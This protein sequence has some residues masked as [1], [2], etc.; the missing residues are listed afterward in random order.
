[1]S[2]TPPAGLGSLV[3]AR[4]NSTSGFEVA[5][6]IANTYWLQRLRT[7]LS[8][9]RND[10]QNLR[11]L[12]NRD[13]GA[14][15]FNVTKHARHVDEINKIVF[16][17]VKRPDG[18]INYDTPDPTSNKYLNRLYRDKII[19]LDDVES[20]VRD[21]FR[22]ENPGLT[23]EQLAEREP[24][25]RERIAR[26]QEPTH[27]AY[28][29][30]ETAA[31]KY[32]ETLYLG[33]DHLDAM[34]A[35]NPGHFDH[36][37]QLFITGADPN[38]EGDRAAV[39]AYLQRPEMQALF[40]YDN[41]A[42][43]PY[44]QEIEA[45]LNDPIHSNKS[46]AQ[47]SNEL[48]DH[49]ARKYP[50]QSLIRYPLD[51]NGNPQILWGKEQRAYVLARDAAYKRY[52]EH[53][54]N[55]SGDLTP[56]GRRLFME[57][58]TSVDFKRTQA[59]ALAALGDLPDDF[60]PM[61]L[62]ELQQ[63]HLI[64]AV[65][66][67]DFAKLGHADELLHSRIDYERS[68][69]NDYPDS[70]KGEAKRLLALIE[71]GA[72]SPF[73]AKIALTA[74]AGLVALADMW[75]EAD[76]RGGFTSPEFFDY[77]KESADDM[78]KALPLLIA[79]E[80]AA[81][82]ASH[83]RFGRATLWTLGALGTAISLR[84]VLDYVTS[85]Y[86]V[87]PGQEGT[88]AAQLFYGLQSLDSFIDDFEK[89]IGGYIEKGLDVLGDVVS[90]AVNSAA[91]R[92]TDKI[93]ERLEKLDQEG[94]LQQV[95]GETATIVSDANEWIIGS[96]AA[97]VVGDKENNVLIHTGAGLVVGDEGDDSVIAFQAGP[98][99][100]GESLDGGIR[101][102]ERPGGPW[103][104]DKARAVEIEFGY[105]DDIVKS[106]NYDFFALNPQYERNVR[107]QNIRHNSRRRLAECRL[108]LGVDVRRRAC[109]AASADVR[110]SVA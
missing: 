75:V 24:E 78:V 87:T 81:Q 56:E 69:I 94:L 73:A 26:A 14:L 90:K 29:R 97:I 27:A 68:R 20:D 71:K 62:D 22:A 28:A 13:R 66:K 80:R 99:Y 70:I 83:T 33:Q 17:F 43:D 30:R 23:P 1:M 108:R 59:A 19:D 4:G 44:F 91:A 105:L 9:D 100:R 39:T 34:K 6:F 88:F 60:K 18:S 86:E 110:W 11:P 92:L 25:I 16:D 46:L 79:G 95:G 49:L 58:V 101:N 36:L 85:A 55:G 47:L 76:R 10:P 65:G 12:P 54:N 42:S 21:A 84:T 64:E 50:E 45:F 93:S 109:G 7:F 31:L 61:S 67:K 103:T 98:I 48:D 15:V 37:Q 2:D 51:A 35:K 5:H 77:L 8:L 32:W 63:R 3:G 106:A 53:Y 89:Q 104:E 82:I 102:K 107:R 57:E 38:I 40:D 52:S 41:M 72:K 74:G 96:D